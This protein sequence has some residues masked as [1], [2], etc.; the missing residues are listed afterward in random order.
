MKKRILSLML[1][2]VI[3]L[4]VMPVSI[5]TVVAEDEVMGIDVY[6]LEVGK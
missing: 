2:V 4:Q 1:A 5:L 3:L 6:D